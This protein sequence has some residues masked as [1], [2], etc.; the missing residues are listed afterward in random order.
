[1]LRSGYVIAYAVFPV[2]L[3]SKLHTEIN[4]STTEAEYIA[5]IQVMRS[6][7]NFMA[8]TKGIS[9]ILEIDFLKK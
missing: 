5:L 1:M 7:I 4:P 3:C 6:T 9:F 2:L 8:L